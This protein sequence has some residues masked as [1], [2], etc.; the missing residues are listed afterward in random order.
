MNH[1]A[2]L[3]SRSDD[4]STPLNIAVWNSH[5]PVA[6]YLVSKGADVNAK[7]LPNDATILMQAVVNSR[8]DILKLLLGAGAGA[9]ADVNQVGYSARTCLHEACLISH[10]GMIKLILEKNPDVN[11]RDVRGMTPLHLS[12][13]RD[14]LRRKY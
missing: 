1:G 5:F 13:Q 12:V 9:G 8:L 10:L 3:E 6:R 11:A 2:D 14:G 7:Y 4:Q